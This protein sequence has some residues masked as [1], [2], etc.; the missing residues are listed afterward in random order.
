MVPNVGTVLMVVVLLL[1]VPSLAAPLRA[2][3]A[4]STLTIPYQGRLADSSGNPLTGKYNLEF[5]IYDVP[6]GEV[7]LW[8][9]MGYLV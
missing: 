3:A 8:T 6:T 5:R 2:P 4:T 9:G 7:P 1:T